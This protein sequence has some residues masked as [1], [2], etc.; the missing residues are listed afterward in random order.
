MI[1]RLISFW[2]GGAQAETND[3]L[4]HIGITS[5]A[6]GS[7][8]RQ[9]LSISGLKRSTFISGLRRTTRRPNAV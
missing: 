9:A 4:D 5:T 2:L 6:P 7:G 3:A 1:F 8:F